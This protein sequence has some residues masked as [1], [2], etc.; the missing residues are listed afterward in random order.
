MESNSPTFVWILAKLYDEEKPINRKNLLKKL[1]QASFELMSNETVDFNNALASLER[2]KCI[3][4][5]WDES[6]TSIFVIS[7]VGIIKFRK[8]LGTPLIKINQ[9]VDKFSSVKN[10]K[11]LNI[12]EKIKNSSDITTLAVKLCVDNTPFFIEF[13]NF[14]STQLLKYNIRLNS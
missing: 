11:F 4:H 12:L 2:L 7:E 8:D 13:L 9:N 1:C 10:K 14:A 3:E 6:G 5:N